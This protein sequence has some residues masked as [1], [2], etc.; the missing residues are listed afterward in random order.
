MKL[1]LRAALGVMA[2]VCALSAADAGVTLV[3]VGELPGNSLDLSGLEGNICERNSTNC[4]PRATMGGFGSALAYTGFDN[5]FLAVPDRGPF[6]GRTLPD[7][8]Y[9]NRFHFRYIA[10][11]VGAP[12]P[13][14]RSRLMDTRRARDPPDQS[15]GQ[16]SHC[17]TGRRCR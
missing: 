7:V 3:G 17:K 2:T 5:V 14:I 9:T 1:L 16:V 13:N 8:P 11:D 4:I 15:T 10:V 6:D 12:F